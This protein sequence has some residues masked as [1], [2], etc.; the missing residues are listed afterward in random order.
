MSGVMGCLTNL[1][2]PSVRQNNVCMS[3]NISHKH[4]IDTVMVAIARITI[5]HLQRKVVPSW[6]QPTTLVLYQI[7]QKRN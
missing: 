3:C 4:T 5:H 6:R 2:V 1:L 7:N